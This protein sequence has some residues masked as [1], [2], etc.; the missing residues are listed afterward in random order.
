MSANITRRKLLKGASAAVAAG[1]IAPT[2]ARAQMAP[3]SIV[4][5]LPVYPVS[6]APVLNNFTPTL[7]TQYNVFDTLLMLDFQ[8][9]MAVR[10]ALAEEWRRVDD[11]TMDLR[12]RPGVRFHDGG[13]LTANDVAFTFSNVHLNG[14]GDGAPTVHGQYQANIERVEAL[15]DLTVRVTTRAPDPILDTR[16]AAW[17]T[18]IASRAAFEAAGGWAGWQHAPIGTG[19]YRIADV[20]TDVR[21]VLEAFEDYWGG[22]PPFSRIEFRVVSELAAR[23]N[24]LRAGD[25]DLITDVLPDQFAQIEADPELEVVGGPI[26][27][28]LSTNIDTY[29][30]WLSDVRVRR[31]MSLA[32]DRDLIIETLWDGRVDVP[33]GFQHPAFGDLYMLDYPAPRSDPDEARRLLREAG[34]AG[35]RLT[36]RTQVDQY[37]AE[38][39]TTQILVEMFRNVGLEFEISVRENWSQILERPLNAVWNGS[40]FMAMPDPLGMLWRLYGPSGFAQARAR[41]WT[42]AE[43]NAL[44]AR[45]ESTLNADDRRQINRRM[46][47]IVQ[48]DDPPFVILHNNGFFYGKR[49]EVPWATYESYLMDFGPF[50]PAAG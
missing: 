24:G 11:R 10:P 44:G 1:A 27:N 5:A 26:A 31:A 16:L 49:R 35:E 3:R 43:F 45:L 15:D 42:N 32:V 9:N 6:L 4:V 25:Y 7:R 12:L 37:P 50:N 22:E 34:Y 41:S 18:Q 46:M 23:I 36:Y 21:L 17:T 2:A 40:T 39:A 8:D 29:G 20:E 47:D 33:S 14:S 28:I 19:P 48:F 30:P 38:L 13:L